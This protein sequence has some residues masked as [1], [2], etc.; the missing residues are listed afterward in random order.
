MAVSAGMALILGGAVP[1]PGPSNVDATASSASAGTV[2]PLTIGAA[3][4]AGT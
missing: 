4:T 1:I 3:W 2:S